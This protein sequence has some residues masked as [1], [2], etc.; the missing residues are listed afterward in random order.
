MLIIYFFVFT[1][2]LG[3][4]NVCSCPPFECVC[5]KNCSTSLSIGESSSPGVNINITMMS[6]PSIAPNTPMAPHTPLDPYFQNLHTAD[7]FSDS[8]ISFNSNQDVYRSFVDSSKSGIS[9]RV[10]PAIIP[11][12][13]HQHHPPPL[14]WTPNLTGGI[15]WGSQHHHGTEDH[16]GYNQEEWSSESWGSTQNCRQS[17]EN[18]ELGHYNQHNNN[19]S[20]N[21]NNE[22]EELGIHQ[23]HHPYQPQPVQTQNHHQLHYHNQNL[24]LYSCH[25]KLEVQN[26]PSDPIFNFDEAFQPQDIFA[27][28][29]PFKKREDIHPPNI[30][31]ATTQKFLQCID[32]II[33]DCFLDTTNQV[34]ETNQHHNHQRSPPQTIFELDSNT[35]ITSESKLT[36]LS[37]SISHHSNQTSTASSVS[38]IPHLHNH[39]S[40]TSVLD[41]SSPGIQTLDISH[42]VSHPSIP[43]S[44]SYI[45]ARSQENCSSE[46]PGAQFSTFPSS[47]S[48]CPKFE[49]PSPTSDYNNY[50]NDSTAPSGFTERLEGHNNIVSSGYDVT[51]YTS[52]FC[53]SPS[54][55]QIGTTTEGKSLNQFRTCERKPLLPCQQRL[56][57]DSPS[58]P[59]YGH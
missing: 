35:T 52:S 32:D 28:E 57:S 45:T 14:N 2:S 4:P 58:S 30:S 42:N 51:V 56:V 53:L 5:S 18:D 1:V 44:P 34:V 23:D 10:G 31:E 54:Q 47:S 13:S 25:T 55:S 7:G 6:R 21:N 17:W 3:M 39:S 38:L 49:F 29:Q 8:A 12:E 22:N 50:T 26:D 19:N 48:V 9:Y 27:L 11:E 43:T 16:P 33:G 46:S 36:Y 15:D 40:D 20:N 37:P 24:D 59:S 41:H